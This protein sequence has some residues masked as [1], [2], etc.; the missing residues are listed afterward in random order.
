MARVQ[1]ILKAKGQAVYRLAPGDTVLEAL[2]M[3]AQHNIGAVLITDASHLAGIFTE[4]HYARNVFLKGRSSPKTP[5]ADVM[6]RQVVTV[7]P[8]ADIEAC[9][10]LM[11]D[12]RIRHLPVVS[13]NEIV[14]VVSLGD[15]MRCIIESREFDID[16]LVH[17]ISQ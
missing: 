17:Y 16:Q 12:K 13:D 1:D 15:L 9:I 7:A 4:R 5:L 2:Q 3:M 6:V 8:T 11:N 14:G 10:A